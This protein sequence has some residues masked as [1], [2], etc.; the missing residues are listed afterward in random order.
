MEVYSLFGDIE[1]RDRKR[2]VQGQVQGPS[3]VNKQQLLTVAGATLAEFYE[4]FDSRI[5]QAGEGLG[6]GP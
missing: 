4:V 6:H 5:V 1:S 3:P 2:V